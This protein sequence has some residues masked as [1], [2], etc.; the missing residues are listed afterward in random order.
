VPSSFT[1]GELLPIGLNDRPVWP[2]P[3]QAK[4][5]LAISPFLTRP[6]V[7]RLANITS[8]RILVSRAETL[9][10]I[11]SKL[12]EG[13]NVN[14]LQRL[15]EV[16][17]G[18]DTT[19]VATA[20]SE[21]QEVNQGLHAKTFVVDLAER[22]SVVVTGSANLTSEMWGNN[23]EF[24]AI[25]TGPTWACG[26]EAVLNGSA[27]VPGLSRLLEEY[28]VSTEAGI[29]D[30]AI[31]T[32]YILE[33][34]HRQLAASAP[35]LHITTVDADRVQATLT[36][37][38][39]G[40]PPGYTRIWLAS[41]PRDSH[42]KD[43]AATLNWTIAPVNTTPFVAVE[44]TA[45]EGDSKVTR[46]CVLKASL[47]GAIDDRRQNAVFSILRSKEDVLRYLVFLLGS[48]TTDV[49]LFEPL[50]RATG[51]D[52]DA[53][54]RVASLVEELRSLPNGD[55]LVPEGFDDLWDVVWQVH[56]E[57]QR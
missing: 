39:D 52:E 43:L 22:R 53:L 55:E 17:P 13:W 8:N 56:R 46:R 51:R 14:V 7:R 37:E 19:E 33:Q 47:T 25:L 54:A 29:A 44:T 23:I 41:L 15:A 40:N 28:S 26:V 31:E 36:L 1:D 10:Q 5:L 12:L 2:F 6:A 21:L 50:V 57:R 34:F 16:D 11:G 18:D 32:S 49:A 38:I 3:D 4:R 30:A 20:T 45:G 27:E 48:M 9:E 24:D 35:N 42:C